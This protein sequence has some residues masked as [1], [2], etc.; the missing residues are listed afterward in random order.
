M[1]TIPGNI[2]IYIFFSETTMIQ[3]S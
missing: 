2:I 3:R 1:A